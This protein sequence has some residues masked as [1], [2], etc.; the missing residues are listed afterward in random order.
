MPRVRLAAFGASSI[1]IEARAY[2]GTTSVHEFM[3]VQEKLLAMIMRQVEAAGTGM[4]FPSTTAYLTRD[5]GIEG[6]GALEEEVDHPPET[7]PSGSP[8]RSEPVWEEDD[9][10][11]SATEEVTDEDDD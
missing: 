3:A 9:D 7:Q 8:S 4:A 10:E 2:V 5:G 11:G 1:D 6:P